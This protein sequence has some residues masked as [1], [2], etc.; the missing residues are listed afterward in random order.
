MELVPPCSRLIIFDEHMRS[1][2][3]T[4]KSIVKA[5]I[6]VILRWTTPSLALNLFVIPRF[7]SGRVPTVYS[8]WCRERQREVL[9]RRVDRSID[10]VWFGPFGGEVG[11]ELLYWRGFVNALCRNMELPSSRIGIISRGHTGGWYGPADL[12]YRDLFDLVPE[13][14]VA[15]MCSDLY[16][17][18]FTHKEQTVVRNVGGRRTLW[19]H[20]RMMHQAISQF[21]SGG[22]PLESMDGVI[23]HVSIDTSAI[24]SGSEDLASAWEKVQRMLPTNYVAAKVYSGSNMNDETSLTELTAR[25]GRI[26]QQ[27]PVV[28]LSNPTKLDNHVD[29]NSGIRSALTP[30]EGIT[31]RLN[32]GLQALVIAHAAGFV[33]TYGGFSYL[34]IYLRIPTITFKDGGTRQKRAHEIME[35]H[36]T[37][38][39]GTRYEI[40]DMS[41]QKWSERIEEF[42]G[43]LSDK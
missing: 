35:E 13:G 10:K 28:S 27:I 1:L 32:L 38:L 30:L 26:S 6:E 4:A 9:Q 7:T 18:S 43:R 31:P 19:V 37:G 39:L 22:A 17:I 24:L 12:E 21:R 16:P 14:Q 33:G 5:L 3:V 29:W 40:V 34:G 8:D 36:A 41:T 11:Y 20:P 15:A 42:V 23:D 25:I 2:F